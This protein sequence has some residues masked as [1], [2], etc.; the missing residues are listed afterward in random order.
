MKERERRI[1]AQ[2]E[3]GIV[4]WAVLRNGR[5]PAWMFFQQLERRQ[6]AKVLSLLG[7]L[8]AAARRLSLQ[9]PLRGGSWSD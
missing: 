4:E 2:G 9:P 1:A 7:R 3:W 6:R 5:S 8:G